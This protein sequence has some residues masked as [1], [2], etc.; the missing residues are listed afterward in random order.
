[1]IDEPEITPDD[2]HPTKPVSVDDKLRAEEP[3]VEVDD[4]TPS[5]PILVHQQ[6]SAEEPPVAADDTSP[7]LI[8]RQFLSENWP[9]KPARSASGQRALAFLILIAAVVLTSLAGFI[10]MSAEDDRASDEPPTSIA[11]NIPASATPRPTLA[12]TVTPR[13]T[14]VPITAAEAAVPQTFPTAASNEIAVALLNP[15]PAAPNAPAIPRD[16]APFTIRP[17]KSRTEVIQYTVAAG[18]TLESIASNFGLTDV[19]SLVWANKKSKLVPLRPGNQINIL[20]QDGVYYEVTEPVTIAA[21]AEKFKVDPFTIIDTE[22]NELFGSSPETLLVKGMWVVIPGGESERIN[23][24][25]PNP[26]VNA[27]GASGVVSGNY[28]LWG[29]SATVQGGSPP[30]SRPLTGSFTWMQGYSPDGHQG[31]DLAVPIGTPVSAAGSGTVVFAG[32]NDTGYGNLVV[33]AHGASFSMYGHLNNVNVRCGQQVSA[34]ANIGTS[35]N[36]G[37][38]SGPHLH[39]EIRDANWNTRNPQDYVGF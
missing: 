26:N 15:V 33:I 36:T 3:P 21:V 27:A 24:L 20:P 9:P 23:L 13:P 37:N 5:R 30:Y 8:S 31:V 29:C 17:L 18:D 35:G 12:P 38:S 22:Y 10:W 19:Y 39:F 4:T 34:G 1:M 28:T 32:G 16:S 14:D 11:Q 7:S 6:L 2:T 25:P